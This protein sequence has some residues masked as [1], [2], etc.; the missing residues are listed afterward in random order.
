MT[1][2][3]LFTDYQTYHRDARNKLTHYL[4]IPLIEYALL[5]FL[6]QIPHLTVGGV[7]VDYA[8]LFFVAVTIFYLTLSVRLAV[9][10]T[11]LSLPLYL[12]ATVTPWYVGVAAF[13][14]GWVL[15]FL[16]HHI[17]GKKPAFLTNG[18]HLLIGPLWITSHLVEKLGLW[19][20]HPQQSVAG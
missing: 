14:V 6:Y 11:L 12:L 10:M 17:E 1:V 9:A 5:N 3:Q 16:G 13:V 7:A 8:L 18:A 20:P 2:E 19:R 4:G 15:Q